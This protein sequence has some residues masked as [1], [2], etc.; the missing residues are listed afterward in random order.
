MAGKVEPGIRQTSHG[1]Q[2]YAKVRG[3]FVS[4]HFPLDTT[5]RQLRQHREDLRARAHLGLPTTPDEASGPIFKVDARAYL[6]LVSKMPSFTDREYRINEWVKVFGHR[7]RSTI[8]SREIRA[9]LEQWRRNGRS[10]GAGGLS[11]ASLNLRRT[12][13]MHL[14]S[15]LDGKSAVNIVKDVP[16]YKE[17][18]V[19]AQDIPMGTISRVV[20]TFRLTSKT[21]ARLRVLQWLGWP[22]GMIQQLTSRDLDLAGGRVH[23]PDR[24]KAHGFPGGWVPVMPRAMAALRYFFRIGAQG[25]FSTSGMHA[26]LEAHCVQLGLP[27]FNPYALKHSF[28]TWAATRVKDND[29][30]RDLLRTHSIDRYI[31]G[32]RDAR[33]EAARAALIQRPRTEHLPR[34]AGVNSASIDLQPTCNFSPKLS[35]NSQN[36]SSQAPR[37]IRLVSSA[38]T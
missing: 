35:K 2:V 4:K 14:Y 3:E 9:V 33:M 13:L 11:V 31:S 5:L 23:A 1:W 15:L 20:R 17:P 8:T 10:K 32:A 38:K 36:S 7:V 18:G 24:D 30:L 22:A 27:P 12:A 28:G 29:A 6:Q 16:R 25:P 26:R 21:R 37:L 34:R 19:R